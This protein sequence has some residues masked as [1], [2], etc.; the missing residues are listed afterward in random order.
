MRQA[1]VIRRRTLLA[2][3]AAASGL[4]ALPAFSQNAKALRL[5]VPYPA[6]GAVDATARLLAEKLPATLQGRTV[7]VDNRPGAG[8]NI[9]TALVAKSDADGSTLLVTTNN[10]TVNLS[11]YQKPGYAL[12]DFA[13]IAQIGVAGFVI[14]AHPSTNFKTLADMLSAARAK[15]NSISFGTGGNGH[16]AHLA[17]ELLKDRAK[18]SMQHVPYKGSGP[19]TT[20]LLGGQLPVGLISVTA[21]QPFVASGQ[22]IGLAVTTK[23]RWPDMPKVPT[24][25][26]SGFPG[27]DYSA[28]IGV[29][30][31]K[32]MPE[33]EMAALE[34]QLLAISATEDVRSRLYKQ[35]IVV[36]PKGRTEFTTAI[37]HDAV[38]NR[39]LVKTIGVQID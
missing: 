37:A 21:A 32:G 24:V 28:W 22:L 11:L 12:D 6:G 30:G 7:M 2:A 34:R 19:L 26:E 8:G 9:A 33:A 31:R 36:V 10:H 25:E 4:C 5:V 29:L 13:P 1:P 3:A 15:P 20:D 18:V 39:D 27:Y 17:A 14:V 16:P 35:G 23:D 38:L